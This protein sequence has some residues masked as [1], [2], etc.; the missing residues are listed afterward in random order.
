MSLFAPFIAYA[1]LSEEHVPTTQVVMIWRSRQYNNS[2]AQF[3]SAL[4]SF[5][6]VVMPQQ[7]CS[8]RGR[9]VPTYH[10]SRTK[11]FAIQPT[12]RTFWADFRPI[13]CAKRDDVVGIRYLRWSVSMTQKCLR[14]SRCLQTILFVLEPAPVGA[15]CLSTLCQKSLLDLA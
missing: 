2:C 14:F 10:C 4:L 15:R 13:S 9:S 6:T 8:D 3:P 1:L 7:K 11:F 5:S 12:V